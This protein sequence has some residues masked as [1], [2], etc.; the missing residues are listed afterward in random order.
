[1]HPLRRTESAQHHAQRAERQRRLGQGQRG[2]LDGGRPGGAPV[3]GHQ[4][5]SRQFPQAGAQ[6]QPAAQ[7]ERRTVPETVPA[8]CRISD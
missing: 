2:L 7:V 8:L 5:Q 3:E 4:H 6:H 1:M